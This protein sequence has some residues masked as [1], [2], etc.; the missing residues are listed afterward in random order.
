[1]QGLSID[2]LSIDSRDVFQTISES[3]VY[4]FFGS[5]AMKAP[6]TSTR[7]MQADLLQN[8]HC[9]LLSPASLFRPAGDAAS[10]PGTVQLNQTLSFLTPVRFWDTVT[11]SEVK[12][13]DREG[14]R[15]KLK[16][17]CVNPVGSVVVSGEALDMPPK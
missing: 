4:L 3:D 15:A 5:Q 8:A 10:R 13:I 17:W 9:P 1:M 12:E 14:N 16:T 2:S 11:A 7:L 6:R